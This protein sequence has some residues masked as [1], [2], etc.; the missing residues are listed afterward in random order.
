MVEYVFD[1]KLRVKT[2]LLTDNTDLAAE[3]EKETGKAVTYENLQVELTEALKEEFEDFIFD[4]DV[5][6]E[7]EPVVH[8]EWNCVNENEN[9]YMCSNCGGEFILMDGTPKEYDMNWCCYCGAKI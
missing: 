1:Y 6:F 2:N 7:L 5:T 4:D 9:V 8:A 3:T